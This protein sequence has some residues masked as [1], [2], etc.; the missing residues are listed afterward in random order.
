MPQIIQ[1]QERRIEILTYL[2][3]RGQYRLDDSGVG[4]LVNI[5]QF[6]DETVDNIYG[7]H[8]KGFMDTLKD[9][10]QQ[11]YKLFRREY[12]VFAGKGYFGWD[13]SPPPPSIMDVNQACIR[14]D[15]LVQKWRQAN[16][17]SQYAF[18]FIM[19]NLDL[20]HDFGRERPFLFG[21]DRYKLRND[22]YSAIYAKALIDEHLLLESPSPESP[23]PSSPEVAGEREGEELREEYPFEYHD[24]LLGVLMLQ[25][26][27]ERDKARR[28]Q[29]FTQ[30]YCPEIGHIIGNSTVIKW[31]NAPL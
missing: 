17:W 7:E 11:A 16:S 24:D 8:G 12:G 21:K 2:N 31:G 22:A 25:I 4:D 26:H 30:Q 27:R 14:A 20:F 3:S 6:Y 5:Y 29:D 1:E 23:G 10:F 28:L 15:K 18:D 13:A 19:T 9:E